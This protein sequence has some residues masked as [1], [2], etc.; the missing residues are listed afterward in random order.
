MKSVPKPKI[1]PFSSYFPYKFFVGMLVPKLP[2]LPHFFFKVD[3]LVHF[4]HAR[5]EPDRSNLVSDRRNE[6]IKIMWDPYYNQKWNSVDLG[7]LFKRNYFLY[8]L[9]W[10][11]HFLN[12][13][14]FNLMLLEHLSIYTLYRC[15]ILKKDYYTAIWSEFPLNFCWIDTLLW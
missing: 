11:F 9:F 13:Y 12:V 7:Y 2:Y 10:F 3:V 8:I 14:I 4:F 6:V 1:R 5:G 15:L